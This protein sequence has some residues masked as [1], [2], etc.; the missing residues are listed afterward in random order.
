M[1]EEQ[2]FQLELTVK[3]LETILT[4]LNDLPHRQVRGIIDNVV[5]QVNIANGKQN[6][7]DISTTK[8]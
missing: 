6:E 8:D 5:N 4:A 1:S 2:K 7:T 3:E